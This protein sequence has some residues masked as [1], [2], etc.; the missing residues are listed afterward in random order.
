[1]T[2]VFD[3]NQADTGTVG[4]TYPR[5]KLDRGGIGVFFFSGYNYFQMCQSTGSAIQDCLKPS[6]AYNIDLKLDDGLA[7]SGQVQAAGADGAAGTNGA[8][9]AAWPLR[10]RL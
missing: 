2:G 10:L 5:T 1:M 8:V 3:G 6:E 4:V 7:D 9:T